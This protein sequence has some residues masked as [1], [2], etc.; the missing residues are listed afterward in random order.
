MNTAPVEEI[1]SAAPPVEDTGSHALNRQLHQDD[2]VR[3][4]KA[5]PFK[6]VVEHKKDTRSPIFSNVKKAT[7]PMPMH[8]MP[9]G[10][11]MAG[12]THPARKS[13]AELVSRVETKS[14][15]NFSDLY[16]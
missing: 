6:L 4:V 13:V 10:S 2:F 1:P 14:E 9:D 11:Q 5:N 8:I 15:S 3:V 16:T 12:A 7:S